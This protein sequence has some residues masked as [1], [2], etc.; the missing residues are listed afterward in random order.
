[1]SFLQAGDARLA[2]QQMGE[3]PDVVLVHGLATNRAFWYASLAQALRDRYR[4]TLFDLRGHGYSS[5]PASGYSATAMAAD[6]AALVDGLALA[7]AV[8]IAHSYGGAVALEYALSAPDAVRGLV[9]MDARI[10]TLQP[11]QWLSDGGKLSAFD[12]EMAAADGRDWESEPQLG[13]TFLESM[14]RLRVEG[15]EPQNR[16]IF[17]PF[18][19]GK[20]GLRGARAFCRLMDETTMREDA[21]VPGA[22]RD[23]IAGL[24]MP[25][26]LLYGGNSHNLPSGDALAECVP[27]S[28][29]HRLPDVGHF[30]PLSHPEMVAPLV[31]AF[32]ERLDGAAASV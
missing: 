7:P 20:S 19:Q 32:L 29:Y 14:A 11:R 31:R 30:F 24:R 3:G 16:D 28:E 22:D 6:L 5:R 1:M 2:W 26:Q 4:V 13:L 21:L 17:T 25:L 10:N 9:L 15:Y 27:Q 23:A 8:V 18:G 12:K